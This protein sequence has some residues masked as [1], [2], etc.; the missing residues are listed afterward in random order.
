MR[1]QLAG[2]PF[3]VTWRPQCLQQNFYGFSLRGAHESTLDL[4]RLFFTVWLQY[5]VDNYGIHL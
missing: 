2:S 5:F 4:P 1:K 3:L